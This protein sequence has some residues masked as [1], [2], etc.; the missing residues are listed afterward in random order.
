[1]EQSHFVL[2]GGF[3]SSP[4]L[5]QRI[6]ERYLGKGAHTRSQYTRKLRGIM[7]PENPYDASFTCFKQ[8]FFHFVL[9]DTKA[10]RL[11]VAFGLVL[12]RT[13]ELN[14]LKIFSERCC[15][16]SYGILI[17]RPYDKNKHVGEEIIADPR[18]KK[19]YVEVIQW[20]IKQVCNLTLYGLDTG[21]HFIFIF[22][23]VAGGNY[24]C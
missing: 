12:D 6:E 15:R 1:M 13:Q 24:Q 16:N 9:A 10:R 14:G 4:Y 2:S 11:A 22:V 19:K 18:D 8:L 7:I 17:K 5:L 21:S 23:R 3:G 20:I